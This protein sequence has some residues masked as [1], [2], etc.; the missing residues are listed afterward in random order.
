MLIKF[1]T[2]II[3]V[4]PHN[5]HVMHIR[6]YAQDELGNLCVSPRG[7][8]Q[9]WTGHFRGFSI[10]I[11]PTLD[12]DLHGRQLAIVASVVQGSVAVLVH[13]IDHALAPGLVQSDLALSRLFVE[14]Q[15]P[16]HGHIGLCV[17]P[18]QVRQHGLGFLGKGHNGD[19][20]D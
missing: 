2:L 11:R 7:G 8:Q 4:P 15:D 16:V 18:L 9:Q 19:W 17:A 10:H 13:T 1:F 6:S 3:A 20:L 12:E 14:I 5:V